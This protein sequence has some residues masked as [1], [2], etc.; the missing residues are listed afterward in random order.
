[1]LLLLLGQTAKAAEDGWTPL[2]ADD[3]FAA[4]HRPTGDWYVGRRRHARSRPEPTLIGK[5]GTGVMINGR[6]GK[7]QALSPSGPTR[8]VEVHVE[9]M[10]AKGSNS[11]VIFHGNYEIQILDSAHRREPTGAHCGG[12]YPRAEGEPGTPTYR[13]IDKGSPPRVNAAKPPGQWQTMDIIFQSAR[14]D[15]ERQKDGQR[16]VRQSRTQRPGDPGERGSPLRPRPE[17]GSQTASPVARSSSRA[18]TARSRFAISAC[19]LKDGDEGSKTA[20]AKLFKLNVPP[21]GFTALFNGK[22]FTGLQVHPK[23]KEMWSIEDGVLKAHGCSRSGAR[24]WRP[25]KSIRITCCLAD[26][27]MP[28]FSDSGIHFRN[29]AP[30]TMAKFGHAEQFNIRS[31]G[32][33]GQLESFATCARRR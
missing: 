10:V 2:G 5:P 32:G 29:L 3:N 15:E 30:A 22:D 25:R 33:M 8:D 12:V 4:W 17:L 27:R 7:S 23:V 18:T 21:E 31:K 24:T 14:F 19:A 9:F 16:Q 13:H 1:M 11:G 28:A 20:E 26:F 6:I